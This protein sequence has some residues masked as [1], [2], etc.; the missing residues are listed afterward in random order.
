VVEAC[1]KLIGNDRIGVRISPLNSFNDI[2]DSDPCAITAYL[3][4]QLST[5]DI[6]YVHVV[7]RDF[8]GKQTGDVLGVARRHFKGRVI[9]NMGYDAA[10]AEQTVKRNDVDAVSF[11][12]KF[13][14][15]RDFPLRARRGA[16]MVDPLPEFF[17]KPGLRGY[18]DYPTLQEQQ[19]EDEAQSRATA[20]IAIAHA[21]G[22]P[23][24]YAATAAALGS[25]AVRPPLPPAGYM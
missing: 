11:G 15:N 13:L 25:Q 19:A 5:F 24:S 22:P 17:Y 18:T 3:C 2:R 6:A 4:D 21:A 16:A 7:R 1:S 12:L 10:E 14:A 9:A 23:P 8:L 20:A